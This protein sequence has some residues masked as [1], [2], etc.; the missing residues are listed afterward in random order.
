M[1][2]KRHRPLSTKFGVAFFAVLALAQTPS[3]PAWLISYPGASVST[4]VTPGLVEATFETA[5]P[6]SDVVAHYRKL[7]EAAG[8]DFHPNFDGIG[9]SI[10]GTAREGDLLILIRRQGGSTTVR[11]DLTAKSAALAPTPA[12]PPPASI[13]REPR[14]RATETGQQHVQNMEKFDSPFRPPPRQPPPTL[15]WPAWLV[16]IDGETAPIRKGVDHVGLKILTSTYAS[17]A[18]RNDIQSYYAD[19]LRA[20]GFAVR[21]QSGASWPANRK[22]WLEAAD[23]ALGAGPGIEIRVEVVQAGSFMQVDLRMTGRP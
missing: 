17:R 16:P 6:A 8:L 5:A 11:A 10:R 1:R 4:N 9:T 13:A 14:S 2:F 23:Y 12:T 7:F 18:E 3:M 19:L 15:S 22:A 21:S 20:H